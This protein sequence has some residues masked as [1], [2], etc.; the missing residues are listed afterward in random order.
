M[1]FP[2]VKLPTNVTALRLPGALKN[3]S[4]SG[5]IQI[6]TTNAI[7]WS[8]QE[9]WALLSVLNPDDQLIM[10][11]VLKAWNRGEIFD[12]TH[13]L[14]PGSGL[15]PNGVGTGA[16]VVD[17]ASQTGDSILT[18]GW[19]INTPLSV[20]AGDVFRF[21]GDEAV[22][23]CAADAGSNG[24]GEVTIVL[25]IPLRQ[26]P[27]D[28]TVVSRAGVTFRGTLIS[29]PDFP[30]SIGPVYYADYTVGFAEALL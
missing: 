4:N 6:R 9:N 28:G 15:P 23:M 25:H 18:D 26:S 3:R 30:A 21:V 19:G 16:V 24:I 8:W 2:R 5:L 13:P 12:I 22:Y 27:G 17:G 11:T 14:T 10:T 7:G 1:A 20:R 29:V